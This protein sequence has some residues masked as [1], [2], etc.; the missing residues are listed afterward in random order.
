MADE[1]ITRSSAADAGKRCMIYI[2]C[3][4]EVWID[5][6]T[7]KSRVAENGLSSP[8]PRLSHH[9]SNI[10]MSARNSVL[11]LYRDI[12]TAAEYFPSKKRSR[13]IASIK[14]E[15]RINRVRMHTFNFYIIML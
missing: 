4:I 1:K 11:V 6:S 15:F 10:E 7:R 8:G 5:E 13:I 2:T 9:T 3:K 12:L 14:D